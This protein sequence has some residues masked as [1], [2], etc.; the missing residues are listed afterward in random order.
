MVPLELHPHRI[1]PTGEDIFF[2]AP[3]GS[4]NQAGPYPYGI[5]TLLSSPNLYLTQSNVSTIKTF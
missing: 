3:A 5:I 2:L 4:S 1:T